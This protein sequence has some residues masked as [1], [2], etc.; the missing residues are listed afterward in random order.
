M[1]TSA[2]WGGALLL[3]SA[4]TFDREVDPGAQIQC[5]VRDDC[6]PGWR[7][8]QALRRCARADQDDTTGPVLEGT[9]SAELVK[10][11]AEVTVFV[12]SDEPLAA[13]PELLVEYG[14]SSRTVSGATYDGD[15]G[16]AFR[17]ATPAATDEQYLTVFARA[18]D[19]FAN[20]TP[21]A[22]IGAVLVDGK[23]PALSR[24]SVTPEV[25]A[26]GLPVFVNL[27]FS[28]AV[29]RLTYQV[30]DAPPVE[31]SN[32]NSPLTSV[33][34]TSTDGGSRDVAFTVLS[35]EDLAGNVSGAL[36]GG[37]FRVDTEGPTVQ[38]LSLDA[39]RYSA[40]APYNQLV[41]PL[42]GVSGATRIS[43]CVEGLGAGCREVEPGTPTSAW[44]VTDPG[45][46]GTFARFVLVAAT[47]AV[48]NRTQASTTVIFDFD[49]PRILDSTV[50]Y[51]R[52]LG[53]PSS[54]VTAVGRDGG[55]VFRFT[56][57]E[58]LRL[59]QPLLVTAPALTVD[60]AEQQQ[61]ST[62]A[63]RAAAR[64]TANLQTGVVTPRVQL[65]DLVGN[66]AEQRLSS[67]ELDADPPGP[68]P[69]TSGLRY[70]RA[71]W[72]LD[73]DPRPV[74]R[75][76]GPALTFE[77]G[78]G[79]KVLGTSAG[80][81]VFLL[82]EALADRDGGLSPTDLLPLDFSALSIETY[83][84]ACNQGAR[85]TVPLVEWVVNL[86]EK[87]PGVLAPNP[88]RLI[89]LEGAL[90]T[91]N[92]EPGLAEWGQDEVGRLDGVAAVLR[93][94]GARW[95][96]VGGSLP[97]DACV[98]P[99][100]SGA[101]AW[102]AEVVDGLPVQRR[103]VLDL[104]RRAWLLDAT[105][106]VYVPKRCASR[107]DG[108]TV[109]LLASVLL[110]FNGN[111][112]TFKSLPTSLGGVQRGVAVDPA[113]GLAVVSGARS[114]PSSTVVHWEQRDAGWVQEPVG[115]A[116]IL[117]EPTV[118][119]LQGEIAV[120][121][122]Q[123]PACTGARETWL[124][125]DAGWRPGQ[126]AWT[127]TGPG[128]ACPDIVRN[129]VMILGADS[130]VV[131]TDGGWTPVPHPFGSA[132]AACVVTSVDGGPRLLAVGTQGQVA[133]WSGTQWSAVPLALGARGEGLGPETR[134][135]L[136]N[137]ALQG[138]P[139]WLASPDAGPQSRWV[140]SDGGWIP[141]LG[142]TPNFVGPSAAWNETVKQTM[143]MSADGGFLMSGG[144]P[145]APISAA[146][147][148]Q[149]RAAAAVA[150][151]GSGF[152]VYGGQVGSGDIPTY[153]EDTWVWAN[154][155]WTASSASN[156]RQPPGQRSNAA[157]TLV[158]G[159]GVLLFGGQK[160]NFM[161]DNDL[162]GA[163]EDP[164][165]ADGVAGTR[166][167]MG[168]PNLVELSDTW[169]WTSAGWAGLSTIGQ[170]PA[171]R[172]ASLVWDAVNGRALLIGGVGLRDTWW[173]D[174]S[175]GRLAWRD[176]TSAVGPVPLGA[177]ATWSPADQAA[178]INTRSGTWLL[179]P[180]GV[181]AQRLVPNTTT[182]NL[183]PTA[184]LQSLEVALEVSE[185][186]D[187]QLWDG[188]R[189]VPVTN[190]TYGPLEA[191]RFLQGGLQWTPRTGRSLSTDYVQVTVRYRP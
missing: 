53:C 20:L 100:A 84:S 36:D 95:Y 90:P 136:T 74:F 189:W 62:R 18:E 155:A 58:E 105:A 43:V 141:G 182:L 10:A 118:L 171:R 183:P 102:F 138:A 26:P 99:T 116:G 167:A 163:S 73:G 82:S 33:I 150:A 23:A 67:V 96:R 137:D 126:T 117:Y 123:D 106:P 59:N 69:P 124:R 162:P 128:L 109:G 61:Q 151:W 80:G 17:I 65:E 179:L 175:E 166:S 114:L 139:L 64:A 57:D 120:T 103:A 188:E 2:L 140:W 93:G 6:P 68:V 1:R 35:A 131:L 108:Y 72:G 21:R 127:S 112:W 142:G 5:E 157:A 191:R 178:L 185:K 40:V 41:V 12:K 71:P 30:D 54:Q 44:T 101:E 145:F 88:H 14:G 107:G 172:S 110:R 37:S 9:V 132:P 160:S 122:C 3:W 32:V 83:D 92:D 156:T 165:R 48:G 7:C 29:R 34:V 60:P 94:G 27:S 134:Q 86:H 104:E 16:Y 154:N 159:M 55:A 31:L 152:L 51:D 78:A 115:D 46:G 147:A 121:G 176:W 153:L 81:R 70:V 187:T 13:Y 89:G 97:I 144:G 130:G 181:P 190:G 39:G 49:A 164:L 77:P 119:A 85:Q 177:R 79:I 143:V 113:T 111:R 186:V 161:V 184:A 173:L 146:S 91:V 38:S 4:C 180:R 22:F 170:P 125:G 75:L 47:D 149:G 15:G 11:G 169:L 52:P 129:S 28:E 19:P 25:V 24:L 50:A 148:P 133:S 87:V 174:P 135:A 98:A 56:V 42:S 8:S 76:D 158:P 63:W 66:R 45:D 168:D